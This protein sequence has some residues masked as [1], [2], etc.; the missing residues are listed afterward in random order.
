[1]YMIVA[2]YSFSE[3]P[4][5]Q[6]PGIQLEISV[7]AA[8]QVL[9]QTESLRGVAAGANNHLDA[10]HLK[11]LLSSYLVSKCVLM[12]INCDANDLTLLLSAQVVGL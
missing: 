1:M 12:L 10:N 8:C 3:G 4:S 2:L 9:M 11:R 5:R 6:E 7:S